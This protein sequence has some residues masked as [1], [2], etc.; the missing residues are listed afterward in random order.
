MGVVEWQFW[1]R[2]LR[3][4]GLVCGSFGAGG[5]VYGGCYVAVSGPG[6]AL[7]RGAVA[8]CAAGKLSQFW[9]GMV[10]ICGLFCRSFRPGYEEIGGCHVAVLGW[11][12]E[13]LGLVMSQF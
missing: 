1:G 11:E 3:I 2:R 4:Q 9:S 8:G 13:D 12:G 6:R 7:P 10:M 5:L